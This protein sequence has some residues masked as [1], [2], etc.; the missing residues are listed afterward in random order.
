VT[1]EE[2]LRRIVAAHLGVILLC[3]ALP[4]ALTVA[5][6]S[7]QAPTYAAHVRLQTSA[8]APATATQADG[9]SSRVLAVATTPALVR[10]TLA[11]AGWHADAVKVAREHVSAQRLGESTIV[12][13]SVTAPSADTARKTAQALGAAVVGFTNKA[14]A[15][16]YRRALRD[17]DRRIAAATDAAQQAG[18]QLQDA[19]SP[20]ARDDA[21]TA[22][23]VATTALQSLEAERSALT[24]S[25]LEHGK[26]VAVA[27]G[28]AEVEQ[29]P[30][31]LVPRVALAVLLGLLVG[32]AIAVFQE[33]LRP[34]IAGIRGLARVLEAPVLGSASSD[35]VALASALALMARR[36][37]VE[38]L[39]LLGVDDRDESAARRLLSA[40][41]RAWPAAEAPLLLKQGTVLLDG[42][43]GNGRPSSA[44]Q[45]T[46]VRVSGPVRF[47]DRFG[48]APAE[49]PSAGVV[50]V[51]SAGGQQS[52][53]TALHDTL[54]G[55]RW[56][57]V[58]IVEA[59]ASGRWRRS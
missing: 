43:A 53:L 29:L 41:P 58:G 51:S 21:R 3:V 5:V 22:V 50:V 30:S 47:T 39:I 59:P 18:R 1:V 6:E 40:L 10:G 46:A 33:T 48:V 54:R 23:Q 26:V 13:L 28:A 15:A 52:E 35:P 38:T 4:V 55:L 31:A 57:V 11:D 56:P 37:G 34:R 7:R 14:D 9:L 45:A 44:D 16:G 2:I 25:D 42:A 36:Q 20:N 8:Q 32:L 17:V 27:G 49:E 12:Q 24:V 19:G